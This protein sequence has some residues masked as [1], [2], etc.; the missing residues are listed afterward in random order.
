MKVTSAC[1]ASNTINKAFFFCIP[2]SNSPTDINTYT[3]N[4]KKLM[5]KYRKKNDWHL[6]KVILAVRKIL[7]TN[8]IWSIKS[9]LAT[10]V[11]KSTFSMKNSH[12]WIVELCKKMATIRRNNTATFVQNFQ[13]NFAK[14]LWSTKNYIL[15]PEFLCVLKFRKVGHVF[16]DSLIEQQVSKF[17]AAYFWS[18]KARTHLTV[19][20]KCATNDLSFRWIAS[21]CW[22]CRKAT[23]TFDCWHQA[24]FWKSQVLIN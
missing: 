7:S 3:K 11:I 18:S 19:S 12:T 6:P 8:E 10:H 14:I 9:I 20:C 13:Y 15:K 22:S 21:A 4:G 24:S 17:K 5:N 2:F 1:T 23:R 16:Y